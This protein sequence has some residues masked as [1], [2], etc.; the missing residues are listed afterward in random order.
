MLPRQLIRV[1]LEQEALS[2]G[3]ADANYPRGYWSSPGA[4]ACFEGDVEALSLLHRFG[5]NLEQKVEWLLQPSPSFTYAHAAA[6]NGN[7]NVLTF[8]RQRVRPSVFLAAD[9]DGSNPLHTLME[10][11]RNLQ[12]ARVVEI[13]PRLSA[14]M[15]SPAQPLGGAARARRREIGRDAPRSI[16][17][18][19]D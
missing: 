3:A 11:S 14:E 4:H 18:H 15:E 2:S 10:S 13:R 16:G 9:G 6:F 5:L 17:M 1:R 8:M 12:T 19:R 7:A